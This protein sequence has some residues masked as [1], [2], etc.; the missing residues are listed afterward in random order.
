MWKM[1]GRSLAT[2]SSASEMDSE[3][4]GVVG[5]SYDLRYRR[6]SQEDPPQVL[7]LSGLQNKTPVS[8]WWEDAHCA[9]LVI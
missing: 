8:R 9:T 2:T 6:L 5:H 7:G 4:L 1:N 3:E